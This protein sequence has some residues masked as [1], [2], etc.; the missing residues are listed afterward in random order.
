MTEPAI[1]QAAAE[2]AGI[3]FLTKDEKNNDTQ[4]SI[5]Q[6]MQVWTIRERNFPHSQSSQI[7]NQ[8]TCHLWQSNYDHV[9]IFG[10]VICNRR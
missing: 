5:H 8:L 9:R 6:A 7:T 2:Q 4:I 10:F 1:L 3:I